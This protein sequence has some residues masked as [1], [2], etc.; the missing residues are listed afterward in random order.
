MPDQSQPP[1]PAPPSRWTPANVFGLLA[2]LSGWLLTL[3]FELDPEDVRTLSSEAFAA[4]LA[5]SRTWVRV[6]NG[7]MTLA[8][9]L[10]GWSIPLPSLRGGGRGGSGGGSGG[11]SIGTGLGVGM[12]LVATSMLSGC[13][14]REVR[15]EHDAQVDWQ[16]RPTC[17]FE[18]FADGERAFLMTGPN[19]CEP[20]PDICPVV[21]PP[22]PEPAPPE[23]SP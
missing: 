16:P 1:T 18:A 11:S 7:L 4:A 12:V 10:L 8:A 13:L 9:T 2:L 20:D 5:E 15:A 14:A 23:V 3:Y 22:E 21:P 17:R 19:T 6:G